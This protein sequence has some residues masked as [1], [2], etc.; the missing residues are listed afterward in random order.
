MKRSGTLKARLTVE[1]EAPFNPTAILAE[2]SSRNLAT[3]STTGLLPGSWERLGEV[4]RRAILREAPS[5][6]RHEA[7]RHIIAASWA[8]AKDSGCDL[9]LSTA[10]AYRNL[11]GAARS[12]AEA[13]NTPLA[14]AAFMAAQFNGDLDAMGKSLDEAQ[15]IE[16]EQRA[17]GDPPFTPLDGE[18]WT[19]F[20][21]VRAGKGLEQQV[22]EN[23]QSV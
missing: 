4:E 20:E 5:F 15:R 2:I 10:L 8:F 22:E 9:S 6:E 14:F 13:R 16:R 18:D 21:K 19:A 7:E 1:R 23:V 3:L 17:G 11:I 12:F